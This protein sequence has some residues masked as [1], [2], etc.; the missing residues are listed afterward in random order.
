MTDKQDAVSS[1]FPLPGW[2]V[3]EAAGA[4]AAA[5]LQAQTMNDVRALEPG[6]WQWNGWLNPKGRLIAL[7]ALAMLDAQRF[8]LVLPDAPAAD[9]AE[10][11]RRFVFRSK[12]KIAALDAARASGAFSAPMAA[13]GS[14][15]S[16]AATD[17]GDTIAFDL[18]GEG[19]PRTLAIGTGTLDPE[20]AA[21]DSEPVVERWAAFDLAHGLPRL[22]AAQSE[23]WT[24]QMLSLER[25]HAYSLKKGCYPGQEIV[26][27]THYLGQ[28]KRALARLSG[29]NLAVG[30]EIRAGD[31]ALGTIVSV[32]GDEALAVLAAERPESGWTCEGMP[33][34]ERHLQDGLAR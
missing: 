25:L 32:A 1:T 26:A 8:W 4:D 34:V 17:G 33:C 28:A 14:L 2:Q 7:F 31:R 10:R 15:F 16:H 19:G 29:S 20:P 27:R 5:F 6:R 9:V 3:V 21:R 30:R 13:K 12:A 23:A 22:P 18:G 11:L 24:P